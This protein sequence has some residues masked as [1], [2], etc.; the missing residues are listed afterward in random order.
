MKIEEIRIQ[1]FRSIKD[2]A[3]KLTSFNAFVGPNGAGKSTVLQALNAFFGEISTFT[4]DDFHGRNCDE[5]IKITVTFG[6]LS[7]A[8]NEDFAHYVRAGKLVVHVKV[9][10]D[11]NG[12]FK[13]TRRGERLIFPEFKAFF[14]AGNATEKGRI[15]KELRERFP[16]LPNATNANDRQNAL[17][18]YENALSEEQKE[19]TESGDE[20]F[21]ISKGVDKFHRHICWVYVPAVKDAS[22]EAEEAKG[23]HLGK[24]IQ[25][26]IRS[27]M[28]YEADLERIRED[29]FRDYA[30]LLSDQRIHLEDL[31]GRLSEKLQSAVMTDADLQ[32]DW[33]QDEKS[34]S[35][36]A[37]IAQV[38]LSERGHLDRVEKFGH[39][40]Q[41]SFLLVILQ[42]LMAVDNDASPTLLLGCEEPELYQ[43]PPQARHLADILMELTGGDAQV[44]L[45]THS[46]YFINVEHFDGIKVCRNH[47]GATTVSSSTFS[48]VVHNY[49]GA[50]NKPLS[51][52]NQA[53]TK[54]AIQTQPKFNEIFFADRVVLV[55]GISDFACLEAFLRLSGRRAD[56]RK[57]G[58]AIVVCDAKS[59]LALTLLILKSF[60]IQYHAIFDCDADCD[61]RYSQEHI[62]DNNAI[63]ALAGHSKL[64]NFPQDNVFHDNL[65]AWR[66]SIEAILDEEF[67]DEKKVCKE[68]GRDAAG[69]LKGANKQP[70]YVAAAMEKAWELGKRFPTLAKVIDTILA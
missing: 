56:F 16:D 3:I 22:S 5:P 29:A 39:G 30:K 38:Q 45:T 57:A 40:L 50:F 4:E 24:L 7:E 66:F 23:S 8:A 2:E 27:R 67:G 48:A 33:K 44:L 9:E 35:V 51:N 28:N 32:L 1:N 42:E 18:E 14:E 25:H 15:F 55:E 46:P 41:R 31:Q 20:L 6:E 43:H 62:R 49:N 11:A 59:S 63:F 60:N 68:A 54:L 26:T 36:Q 12:S 34:V 53:K 52:E 37:P 47:A 19:L 64:E 65:T 61:E 58:A 21:G 13:A 17:I 10:Q 69:Q 70:L